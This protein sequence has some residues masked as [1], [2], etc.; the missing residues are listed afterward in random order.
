MSASSNWVQP[1]SRRN[2]RIV[3][4]PL[5]SSGRFTITSQYNSRI[6]FVVLLHLLEKRMVLS[7]EASRPRRPVTPRLNFFGERWRI[8]PV[9]VIQIAPPWFP[10]PPAGYG[11]IERVIHD[12]TE[13]MVTGGHEVTLFA[14]AGSR[15]SA[16]LIETVPEGIGLNLTWAE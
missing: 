7:A 12:L 2:A 8:S 13:G 6:I 3:F 1:R 11:G 5:T 14:P 4:N 9:R 10:I 15:T 16:R